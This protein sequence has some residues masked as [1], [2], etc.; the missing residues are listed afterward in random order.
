MASASV[1]T[2]A[3][4]RPPLE[5]IVAVAAVLA[6][7][8]WFLE[9]HTAFG[10]PAHPLIIHLPVIF[11]PVLG[12]ATLAIAVSGR[13]FDRFLLPVAAFSVV[14][15]AATILAAGAG[16]AFREDREAAMPPGAGAAE[17]ST[18]ND[19]ADAGS[20]LRLAMVVLTLVL[21]SGLF[22][23][24]NAVRIALRVLAVVLA[25]TAVF[26]VIRTGHL[27]AKLAWGPEQGGPPA[28]FQGGPSGS[29]G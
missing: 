19:H 27:G 22:T 2:R 11:V 14:T 15:M 7:G 4:T 29:G 8:L 12:L 26:F 16:E 17:M 13:L 5:T 1:S 6:Q 24:S 25:L 18:L 3:T 20:T 10:L 21:V 23:K 9:I 28:G